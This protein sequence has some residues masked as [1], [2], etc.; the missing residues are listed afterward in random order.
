MKPVHIERLYRDLADKVG[1]M[2][3]D[4][5]RALTR[6]LNSMSEGPITKTLKKAIAESGKTPC[7]VAR[8]AGI[9][10]ATMYRFLEGQQSLKL[11]SVERLAEHL[12][13]ELKPAATAKGKSTKA[14]AKK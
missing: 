10:P 5:R 12:G 9:E 4:R 1:A 2:R 8:A 6:E 7:G 3:D 13:L 14:T 11:T